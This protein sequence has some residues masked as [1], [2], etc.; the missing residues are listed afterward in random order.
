MA[1]LIE[2][3]IS[4]LEKFVKEEVGEFMFYN[5]YSHSVP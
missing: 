5:Q 1:S 3:W 4:M 2:H